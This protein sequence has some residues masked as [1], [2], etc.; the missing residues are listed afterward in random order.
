MHI[1]F[2]TILSLALASLMIANPALAQ[3]IDLSP[4]QNLLQDIVDTITGPLSIFNGTLPLIGVVL[5]QLFGLLNFRYTREIS[6][7]TVRAL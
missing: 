5:S 7:F 3:S 4:V 2:R 6:D 1:L